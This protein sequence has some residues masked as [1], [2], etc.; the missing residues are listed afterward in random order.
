MWNQV[1]KYLVLPNTRGLLWVFVQSNMLHSWPQKFNVQKKIIRLKVITKLWSL[2]FYSGSLLLL[3]MLWWSYTTRRFLIQPLTMHPRCRS[4]WKKLWTKW[5]HRTTMPFWNIF[6][7][8]IQFLVTSY[9]SSK[10][11]VKWFK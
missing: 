6:I 10:Q 7:F 4:W 11:K 5:G 1:S 9:V 3:W 8:A 2:C